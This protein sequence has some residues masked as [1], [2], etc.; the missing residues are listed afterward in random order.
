M[1]EPRMVFFRV[2]RMERYHGEECGYYASAR[3]EDAVLLPDEERVFPLPYRKK[4]AMG[5][6]NIWYADDPTQHAQLRRDVLEYIR[7]RQVADE[8]KPSES[9][10]HQPDPLRRQRVEQIAVNQ[11]VEYFEGL[12]YIVDS[13][14]K[15]NVGWDLDAR[16]GKRHLRLEVKGLSG[17]PIS[18]E[19]T[20]NEFAA[21]QSH[22]ETY[23]LCVVTEAQKSPRLFIFGHS[24]ESGRWK[25]RSGTV[26]RI[27][28]IESARCSAMTGQT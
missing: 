22:H 23:R 24:P 28:V 12:G 6:S 3:T 26:L 10:P 27:D 5:Q 4:G 25:T 16:Q 1:T 7:T 21:M 20:P 9:I 18:V 15:D 8:W 13:V 17:S 19:L 2:G 11:T 14:E